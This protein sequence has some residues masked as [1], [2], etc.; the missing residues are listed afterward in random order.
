MQYGKFIK[1]KLVYAPKVVV[2][3]DMNIWNASEE[4]MLSL[5]WKLIVFNDMPEDAP[6]GYYYKPEWEETEVE[7]IQNW[8]LTE[9][10][11]DIDEYE[12]YQIIVGGLE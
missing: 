12:A 2:I 8:V 5:G 1:G 7:I 4:Q 6:T 10:P 11:E 3:D 9:L